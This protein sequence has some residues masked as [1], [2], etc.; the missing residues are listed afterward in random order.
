MW[1]DVFY[2]SL[3]SCGLGCLLLIWIIT[4]FNPCRQGFPDLIVRP[5]WPACFATIPALQ[6]GGLRNHCPLGKWMFEH[7]PDSRRLC[8]YEVSVFCP[9]TPVAGRN[10]ESIHWLLGLKT[11]AQHLEWMSCTS[12]WYYEIMKGRARQWHIYTNETKPLF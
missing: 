9:R 12:Q 6:Q 3:I 4:Y 8:Y 11:S 7:L 10:R 2:C 5:S 1:V